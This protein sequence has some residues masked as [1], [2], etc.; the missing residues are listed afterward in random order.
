MNI[1]SIT[2]QHHTSHAYRVVLLVF[3]LVLSAALLVWYFY[4]SHTPTGPRPLTTT[5][6]VELLAT[7]R[8]GKNSSHISSTEDQLATLAELR[9]AKTAVT[10]GKN[11]TTSTEVPVKTLTTEEQKAILDKITGR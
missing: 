5:E 7:L 9:G 4:A 1:E 8:Q 2:P 6:K 3:V 10:T 11:A